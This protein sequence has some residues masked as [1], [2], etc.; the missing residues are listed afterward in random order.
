MNTHPFV[1]YGGAF[2]PPTI[3]HKAVVDGLIREGIA[4]RVILVPS[5]ARWDKAYAYSDSVRKEFLRAFL[6]DIESG[7][8]ELDTTFMDH[9]GQTTTLGMDRYYYEKYG[10]HI[11]QVFGADVLESMPHWDSDPENKNTLLRILPKIILVR[12]GIDMI[13]DGL[14]NYSLHDL[15]IP[16]ASSTAVRE[17]GRVDLLTQNVRTLYERTLDIR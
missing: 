11:P 8:A 13:L 4:E 3:G 5:G 12:K 6:Y 14:D 2:S 9:G 10:Y 7:S 15:D 16:E 17:K 1:I